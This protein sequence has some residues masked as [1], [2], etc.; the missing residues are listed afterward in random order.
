MAIVIVEHGPGKIAFRD[1]E[2]FLATIDWS[3]PGADWVLSIRV[4]CPAETG[5]VEPELLGFDCDP[6]AFKA[7]MAWLAQG[8]PAS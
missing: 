7:L 5:Q 3:P 8:P 1:D 6:D 4:E 2:G